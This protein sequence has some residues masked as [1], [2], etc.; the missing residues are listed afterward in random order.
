MKVGVVGHVE[1]IEFVAVERVPEQG[2]IVLAREWWGEA[3]G[4]GGGAAVELARLAGSS[5]L[6]TALGDEELGRRSAGEL[7]ALGVTVEAAWRLSE[8]QRRGF[9]Y[10]DA[11]GER[12]IT[13]LGEKLRPQRAEPLPWEELGSFDG[14]YF[15][16]GDADALRAA[17]AARVLV[18]TARELRTLQEAGVALDVLVASASDPAEHYEEGDLDPAPRVVAFTEGKEGGRLEPGGR[19]EPAPLP[20]PKADAYGAGDCF[21]AGLTFALAQGLEPPAAARFAAGR[22]AEAMTRRGASG[23]AGR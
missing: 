17:R 22:S 1:W 10:L 21:A 14:V 2:D 7:E 5:T 13:I 8:P 3:A 20:G 16:G 9:C 11:E 4:G 18:A 6:I 15:T 19:W 12:T 23:K